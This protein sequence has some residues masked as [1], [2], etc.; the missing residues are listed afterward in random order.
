MFDI[1]HWVQSYG[2]L[3]TYFILTGII[4]AE[5]GLFFGF[6]LPGDTILFPAG[7]IASQG[8]LNIFLVCSLSFVAAV[9]GNCFGYFFGKHA[10]PRIFKKEDSIFFH[11]DHILKA[12]AFYDKHGGK[13]I[14]LSRFLPIL[15]TFAPI[16]AGVSNMNFALFTFYSAIGAFFWTIGITLA[17]F[18]LGRYIPNIDT[19]IVPIILLAIAV[20]L[21]SS[22]YELFKTPERR[23]RLIAKFRKKKTS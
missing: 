4:F 1:T 14:I 20:P 18:Y 21:L 6:F 16:V 9:A 7:L 2:T 8:Y 23:Q 17:G 19:Y 12:R 13:T 15:R 3:T 5:T 22:V 10:G 11:K